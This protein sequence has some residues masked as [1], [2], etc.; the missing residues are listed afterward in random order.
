[1]T[2]I[3]EDDVRAMRQQQDLKQFI[4]DGMRAGAAVNAHRRGLVLA[5]P[6][7]AAK[8]AEQ[9]L[10]FNRP[11]QWTGFV[12]PAIWCTGAIN[13]S[14]VRV[15]LLAVAAEAERRNQ[16]RRAAA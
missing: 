14:P 12:P 16:Q 13:T 3:S 10:C 2:D 1:M 6:D 9:P 15:A 8:L 5:H 11:D 4:V 7:L